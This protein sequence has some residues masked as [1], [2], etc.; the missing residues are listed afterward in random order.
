MTGV[1]PWLAVAGAGALHGLNPATGW[2]VLAARVAGG[3]RV[4]EWRTLVPV[5][6]GQ[7]A[8]VAVIAALAAL[9]L[10]TQRG[11]LP[12]VAGALALLVAGLHVS[13]HL[14]RRLRAAGAR[15][16]LALW[17]FALGSAHGAGMIL[18][19]ALV[20]LCVSAS[21]ARDITA[22]GSVALA[23]AAVALHLAALLAVTGAMAAL[24]R[25]GWGLWRRGATGGTLQAISAGVGGRLTNMGQKVPPR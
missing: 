13:G 7:A 25:R 6:I 10:V 12:W 11:V 21:P 23:L 17:S 18:V 14:P 4:L 8:S 24:A 15:A 20:P 22:S 2:A 1:W 9:G 19:P 3:G 16:G 5:A